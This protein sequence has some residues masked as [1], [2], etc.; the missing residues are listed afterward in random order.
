[1]LLDGNNLSCGCSSIGSVS[2][3]LGHSLVSNLVAIAIEIVLTGG[4]SELVH[5]LAILRSR[6]VDTANWGLGNERKLS[7]DAASAVLAGSVVDAEALI[8]ADSNRIVGD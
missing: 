6:N 2:G 5:T 3:I 1:M 8:L 7:T 4:S